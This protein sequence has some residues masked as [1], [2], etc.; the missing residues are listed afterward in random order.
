MF[1]YTR[2]ELEPANKSKVTLVTY[3]TV[4][5]ALMLTLPSTLT[6]VE[7]KT[8][9][10]TLALTIQNWLTPEMLAYPRITLEPANTYV[11]TPV[12]CKIVLAP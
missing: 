8:D 1:A 6:M 4:L 10:A 2:T 5:V 7:S 11:Q 3:K 9:L 12:K